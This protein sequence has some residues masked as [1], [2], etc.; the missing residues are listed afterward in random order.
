MSDGTT[1][2]EVTFEVWE[3]LDKRKERGE[4]FNDVITRLI[5]A[6]GIEVGAIKEDAA[7]EASEPEPVDTGEE[8]CHY[9]T[10]SGEICDDPAEYVQEVR[11]DGGEPDELYLCEDHAG[12]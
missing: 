10:I 4:S 9:D 2:V 8:C 5:N 11:Y 3:A 1:T 7:L 12:V 6:T